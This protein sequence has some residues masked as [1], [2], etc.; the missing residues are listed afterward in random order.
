MTRFV[1]AGGDIDNDPAGFS[2]FL[3][4][5][6]NMNRPAK[7]FPLTAQQ[8]VAN[9]FL[10]ARSHLDTTYGLVLAVSLN[11]DLGEELLD[12]TD[13]ILRAAEGNLDQ[14]QAN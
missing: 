12:A 14:Q 10:F 8:T 4:S 6:D 3:A 5:Q 1:E 2:S 11:T 13:L 7:L 9:S